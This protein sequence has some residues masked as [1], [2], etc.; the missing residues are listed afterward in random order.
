[1]S[2]PYPL[3]CLALHPV[4]T[5]RA[6]GQVRG[7]AKSTHLLHRALILTPTLTRHLDHND[8]TGSLPTELGLVPLTTLYVDSPHGYNVPTRQSPSTRIALVGEWPA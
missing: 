1:M 3:P 6:W 4:T 7:D 8:F 5:R 2:Q